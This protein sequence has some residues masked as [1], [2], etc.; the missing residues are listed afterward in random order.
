VSANDFTIDDP[1]LDALV[2]RVEN[3][4]ESIDADAW[5]IHD[6]DRADRTLRRLAQMD[7]DM[8]DVEALYRHRS[9][10]LGLWREAAR[11]RDER[12]RAFLVARLEAF[13]RARLAVNPRA[14]TVHLPAGDLK[15]TA[16]QDAWT[17]TDEDAFVAWAQAN[18]RSDLLRETV[19]PD[20]N[21]VK[22]AFTVKDGKA[23]TEDGEVVPGV[24]V[25]DVDRTFK[26]A[27]NPV[28]GAR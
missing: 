24:A 28:G 4:P 9:N 20:R 1:E 5:L 10:E 27:P 12:V 22:K 8:A 26:P 23:V 13:H 21:A 25:E 14:L 19:A 15:S 17:Y 11:R 6:L 3:D 16:G 2:D 7:A 18:G